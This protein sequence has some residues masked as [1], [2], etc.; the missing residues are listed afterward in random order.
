MLIAN[1]SINH[2]IMNNLQNKQI[3]L[4]WIVNMINYLKSDLLQWNA[5]EKE[6]NRPFSE[7]LWNLYVYYHDL[8]EIRFL[9]FFKIAGVIPEYAVR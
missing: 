5:F 4:Y 1:R 6:S 2:I 3:I 9:Q 7:Y 8:K